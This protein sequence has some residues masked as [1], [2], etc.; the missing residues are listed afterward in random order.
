MNNMR[1][2][3]SALLVELLRSPLVSSGLHVLREDTDDRRMGDQNA[4]K[5]PG[6]L[7]NTRLIALAM[8]L[9]REYFRKQ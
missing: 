8:N 2:A 5:C 3:L 1:P 4:E 7:V 9:E 6:C